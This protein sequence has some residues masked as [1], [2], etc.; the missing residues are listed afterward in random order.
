MLQRVHLD[1]RRGDD[2]GDDFGDDGE[3][4]LRASTGPSICIDG[5]LRLRSSSRQVTRCFNGAVD[6]HRR[7]GAHE[8][9]PPAFLVSA[10]TGPSICI[11]GECPRSLPPSASARC[12]FNGAVDLHRRRGSS[13]SRTTTPRTRLQRGRRSA[14]TER[15][16]TDRSTTAPTCFNGAVDL[17]RRRD[18]VYVVGRRAW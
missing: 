13:S 11:D 3:D 7:R 15:W 6:L 12:C 17:H 2:F 18:P 16:P 5:E 1:R 8:T 9:R 14:S 4:V 10:S